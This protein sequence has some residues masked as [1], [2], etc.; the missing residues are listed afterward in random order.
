M[1]LTTRRPRRTALAA[2]AAVGLAALATGV[3]AGPASA[4]A[5]AGTL[6]ATSGPSGG[7]N[8][9]TMTTTAAKFFTGTLV[10]FQYKA[11]ATT[12]CSAA[13]A[14]AV[15]VSSTA[16]IVLATPKILSSTKIAITVPS[17]VA[18]QG[19]ATSANWLV[20]VYPGSNTTTS[21]LSASAAYSIAAKPTLAVSPI[22]P[23]SGPA[24]GGGTVTVTGTNFITGL[25]AK[26]GS[27]ALTGITVASGTT[28]TATVPPQAA[29]SAMSLSVTTTG[30]TATKAAAYTYT[31]G[32]IV[33]PNTTPTATAATDLDILG[34]GFSGLDFAGA[35][36]GG[37]FKTD[38]TAPADAGAH[39]F[40]VQG[41]Y[42]STDNSSAKTLAEAGE[43]VN[44]L[45]VSDTELICTLNTADKYNQSGDPAIA[46][47]VYTIT[48]VND[49][50]VDAVTNN[51]D[52]S[53]SII[54]SGSTFTVA[55]Y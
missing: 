51:V 45:V 30:G 36:S 13:Y 23:A 38:G 49:G 19:S 55:P 16:G 4:A 41:D 7:T 31:N 26:I 10:S 8:T 20:C 33:T 22:S 50:Q 6:S 44:V 24:L 46:D 12:A 17:T 14:S 11:T 5:V 29:G 39:V 15:A 25:T 43:C 54:S 34:V 47:G 35:V 48:V 21:L 2:I 40:I 42:D 3:G 18:L 27:V 37:S 28:F 9:L 1:K 52:Y 32:I 53:E